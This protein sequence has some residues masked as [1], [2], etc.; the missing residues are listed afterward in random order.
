[1][2]YHFIKHWLKKE[3]RGNRIRESVTVR[4]ILQK[5]A[6]CSTAEGSLE[7]TTVATN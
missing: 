5:E 7:E 4:K 1:M 6:N 3:E 2:C